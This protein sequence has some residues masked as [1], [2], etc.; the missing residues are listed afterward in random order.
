MTLEKVKGSQ[1]TTKPTPAEDTD[2]IIVISGGVTYKMSRAAFLAGIAG[3]SQTLQQVYE[4]GNIVNVIN[5]NE[6]YGLVIGFLD[7][8]NKFISQETIGGQLDAPNLSGTYQASNSKRGFQI[9]SSKSN[10]DTEL[11]ENGYISN[12]LGKALLKEEKINPGGSNAVSL[13]FED[14]DVPTS[15]DT[16][17]NWKIPKDE[18]VGV[19][20]VASREWTEALLEGLKTKQP[21]RVATTANI[22]LSGTQTIDDVALSVDDRVLVKDQSTQT[23]NG[24]YVVKSGSWERSTDANTATELTNAV[25]SVLEGTANG[26]STFRQITTS[27]TLG[28]SNIVWQTFGSSVPDATSSTKGKMK[29]F[30]DLLNSFT[31]GSVTQAAIVAA[32]NG[33]ANK[34]TLIALTSDRSLSNTA[35]LQ[36]IFNDSIDV[37]AGEYVFSLEVE[38]SSL[39]ASGAIF[40]GALGTAGV[41]SINW[42]SNANK[43]ASFPATNQI[44][45][46]NVTTA[47]QITGSSTGTNGIMVVTGRIVFSGSGT[48][49]PAVGFTTAPSSG[50]VEAGS[51]ISIIKID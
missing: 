19:R 50:L 26:Q 39:A 34:R 42:V 47:V 45:T 33:K 36:A 17:W 38:M 48:F 51:S 35:S 25:V 30:A 41:T 46:G 49:I 10:S 5:E 8:E 31:D 14:L 40:F 43:Q 23:N 20:K 44:Q 2:L 21:V 28:S 6:E 3:G 1:L 29:L 11:D 22:T 12:G 13:G 9:A 37:V 15:G 16:E 32:L 7:V 4:E 18:P 27:I 24:I